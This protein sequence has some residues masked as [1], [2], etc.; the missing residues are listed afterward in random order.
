MRYTLRFAQQVPALRQQYDRVLLEL[1]KER[2]G[3][4]AE[5]AA[6]MQVRIRLFC[7]R[8]LVCLHVEMLQAL[9]Q[10]YKT[11]HNGFFRPAASTKTSTH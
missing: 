6:I 4:M 8:M 2:D 10:G 5:K 7:A 9:N 1:Q 3:F 11:E